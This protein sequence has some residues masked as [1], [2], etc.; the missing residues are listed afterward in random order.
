[1]P[2][3]VRVALQVFE[4][5]DLLDVGGPYEVLLTANR[6]AVRDGRAAPFD[7]ELVAAAPGPVT[8]YGGMVLQVGADAGGYDVLVVPGAIDLAP[9]E[10]DDVLLAD[11]A[12]RA[13][14]AS[15]VTSVCTG[16]IVLAAAGVL[17]GVPAATT[18]H[19]D[20]DVLR[21]RLGAD[22]V[23]R[24]RWVDAGDVVTGGGLSSGIA[25]ALHLVERLAD[26]DLAVRTAAQIEYD[27]DPDDGLV[28]PGRGA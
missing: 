11:V 9:V 6:L 28:A 21:E 10:A 26:R 4:Q 18:H 5:A 12:A 14:A 8:L 17:D 13:Q 23:S 3:P 22:V 1:M 16:S 7:V 20:L 24:A 15:L 27:W 2:E 19:E 25:M